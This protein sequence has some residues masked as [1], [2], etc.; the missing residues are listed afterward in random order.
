MRVLTICLFVA[1]VVAAVSAQGAQQ[2]QQQQQQQQ[3]QLQQQQQ[4][5]QRQQRPGAQG[6]A[7]QAQ[8]PRR[9]QGGGPQQG[10][11][12][13]RRPG[14]GQR[15]GARPGGRPGGRQPPIDPNDP[16]LDIEE[17]CKNAIA[18]AGNKPLPLHCD[19]S[20]TLSKINKD[21]LDQFLRSKRAVQELVNCFDD[22]RR[23]CKARAG[24]SLVRD[25]RSLGRGASCKDCDPEQQKHTRELVGN[26]I[27][28]LQQYHP[29]EWRRLLPNIGFLF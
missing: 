29:K 20:L 6:G 5:R 26:A 22:L 11:Q 25:V 13:R 19:P 17:V 28:G 4:Q 24:A 7:A 18:A 27:S 8:G 21:A 9:R 15:P 23:L 3:R 16:N 10:G 2:Q 1:V 12:R 14:Q